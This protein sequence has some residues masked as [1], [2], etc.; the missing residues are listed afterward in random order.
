M[1]N[2]SILLCIPSIDGKVHIATFKS[3]LTLV[4]LCESVSIKTELFT[5][6]QESLISRA[7]NVC[8]AKLLHS[9]HEFLLF[10]DSDV[11]FDAKNILEMMYVQKDIICC[12]YPLKK[13][14]LTFP[15]NNLKDHDELLF[16][17]EEAPTGC[18]MIHRG[19]FERMQT[20][21]PYEKYKNDIPEYEPLSNDGSFFNYFPVGVFGDRY[22]SEDYAFCRQARNLG[23]S[24]YVLKN[25][26][27]THSGG[28]TY[29]GTLSDIHLKPEQ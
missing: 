29:S 25:A 1:N 21:Y 22:L 13:P 10:I 3:I 18:M 26:L 4:M 20:M 11:G 7:R 2:H 12:A 15:V 14:T 8:A 19:V 17:V 28:M 24:I 16:E 5:I 27:L 6:E 23:Y 9:S